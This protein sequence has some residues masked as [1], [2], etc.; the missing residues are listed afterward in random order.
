MTEHAPYLTVLQSLLF[1]QRVAALGTLDEHGHPQVSM[2]PFALDRET[3]HLVIHVSTLSTHTA[4][5][6]KQAA[7]GLMVMQP[8]Q[9]D[10]G[11]HALPRVSLQME[12]SFVD[13]DAALYEQTKEIYITR[14]PDMAF[15]TDFADFTLVRLAPRSV[16]LISGFGAARKIEL[17]QWMSVAAPN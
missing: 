1:Q 10:T 3:G 11:V 12:A 16:R 17:T 5:L 9:V 13:R 8:E 7:A 4:N 14:F 15:M 6:R 2:V